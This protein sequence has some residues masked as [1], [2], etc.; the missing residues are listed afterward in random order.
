M[1]VSDVLYRTALSSKAHRTESVSVMGHEL[2]MRVS[3]T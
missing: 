3:S 2:I 1:L